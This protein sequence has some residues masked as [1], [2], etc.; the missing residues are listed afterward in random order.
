MD[1]MIDISVQKNKRATMI[2]AVSRRINTALSD[3]VPPFNDKRDILRLRK[4]VRDQG[5]IKLT[6]EILRDARPSKTEQN[7]SPYRERGM[8]MQVSL[9]S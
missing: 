7:R 6:Y 1:E 4:Y 5:T 2:K 9:N 8:S 3:A